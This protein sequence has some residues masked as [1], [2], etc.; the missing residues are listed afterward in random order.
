MRRA[1]LSLL[2]VFLCLPLAAQTFV[3]RPGMQ[4][5]GSIT[6][7]ANGIPHIRAFT[8]NDA[9]FLNGWVHA[10]DRLFQMDENRRTASGTLAELLGT[11]ALPSDIQLRTLGLRRAAEFS[12]LEYSPRVNQLLEAYARGV[13]ASAAARPLPPEYAALEITTFQPWT[14]LDS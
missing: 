2:L 3:R 13:N 4:L 7:D 14:A 12:Q 6:R 5:P 10:E 8:D 9:A 1:L 11:A